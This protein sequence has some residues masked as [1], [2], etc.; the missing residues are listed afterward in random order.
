M[1][2]YS[3]MSNGKVRESCKQAG[4]RNL[5]IELMGCSD[6]WVLNNQISRY[7]SFL[8]R[9]LDAHLIDCGFANELE[10]VY[11]RSRLADQ[12]TDSSYSL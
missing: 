5:R 2:Y 8:L 3:H 7:R 4:K 1:F 12:S 9:D 11:Y 6:A 10:V